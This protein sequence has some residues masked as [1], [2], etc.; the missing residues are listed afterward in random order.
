MSGR[1]DWS[2]GRLDFPAALAGEGEVGPGDIRASVGEP[3]HSGV[4]SFR[5][6]P[7]AVELST[8]LEGPY[9]GAATVLDVVIDATDLVVHT[10]GGGAYEADYPA[11]AF[12]VSRRAIHPFLTE[13]YEPRLASID[14]GSSHGLSSADVMPFFLLSGADETE[15]IWVAVSWSGSWH[16]R[17]TKLTG[18]RGHRLVVT[19]L[20][21][22]V[23]LTAGESLDLPS[24]V[25]GGFTGD[26]WSAV[27]HHLQATRPRKHQGWA[28]YNSWFNEYGD[29]TAASM[30]E[31]VAAAETLGLDVVTLD[32]A[33]YETHNAERVD[34]HTVG[35][36]TWEPDPVRFPDGIEPVAAAAT[37]AGLRFG[38]WCEFERAHPDSTVALAH[39]TWMR[40]APQEKLRLIDFGVPEAREW[41]IE[42]VD[43][44]VERWMLGWLK[45]D[46]T[47]HDFAAYWAGNP[48]GELAHIRGLYR[49]LDEIRL[50]HPDLIIEGCASGGGRIDRETVARSDTFWISDQT[51]SPELVRD[52]V[53]NARRLL[54]AQYC[55]LSVAPQLSETPDRFP[56]EWL[57]GVMPGVLGIMDRIRTWPASL[58]TQVAGQVAR[59][60]DIA[61]LL[62]GEPTR[63]QPNR[64]TLLSGWDALEVTS[65]DGAL[66]FAHRRSSANPAQAFS[67]T[68]TWNVFVPH[69]R[70]AAIEVARSREGFDAPEPRIAEFNDAKITERSGLTS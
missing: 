2:E 52:I 27:R 60:H 42:L 21:E 65:D 6:L 31:N 47:T 69:E 55:Y 3:N 15:G 67:G 70:G 34:F 45:L 16:A 11:H 25:V 62:D 28:V 18:D 33:W 10:M 24:V 14:F 7:R 8:L 48:R 32:G 1:G 57:V 41:A 58:R 54:P 35:F 19:T 56:D 51:V 30:I 61:P 59:Y 17:V 68:H 40:S 38:L 12:A 20:A 43:G 37:A 49:V 64:D 9:R 36:G 53:A 4:L 44:M 50:R 29:V 39:P 5:R 23:E 46:M 63:S 22:D 66:L 13:T 26:G